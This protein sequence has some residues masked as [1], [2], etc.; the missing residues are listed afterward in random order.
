[1]MSGGGA[2][3]YPL[4]RPVGLGGLLV[5]FSDEL[6]DTA[7]RAALAFRAEIDAAAIAGVCETATSLTST[8]M[9][10]DPTRLEFD[11]LEAR[12]RGLLAKS[13]A[14]APQAGRRLWR[15]PVAFGGAEGPELGAAAELAGRT[16]QQAIAELAATPVRVLTIG[17]APGQPYLGPL[18]ENWNIP[19]RGG[20]T[21]SVPAGALVVAVRQLVLFAR[22]SPTGWRRV[23]QTAFRPF[24]PD[25]DD[26]FAFR[27]GDEVR[28]IAVS[29]ARLADLGLRGDPDGGATCEPVQ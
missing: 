27:P 19:R 29:A 1:M 5:T 6:T 28:L 20:L 23:G 13:S 8:F 26:P 14:R 2:L 12:L 25:T 24:R 22:A 18:P 11:E 3:R 17:F 7:N 21:A 9:A 4:I 15:I 10:F 16:P